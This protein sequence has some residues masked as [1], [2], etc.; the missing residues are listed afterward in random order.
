MCR[1]SPYL[2]ANSIAVKF[3]SAIDLGI[4]IPHL[5][6]NQ[7]SVIKL[8]IRTGAPQAIQQLGIVQA[9][10]IYGFCKQTNKQ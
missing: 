5:E 2:L 7:F 8:V 9:V 6:C 10:R 3:Q 1:I 4:N